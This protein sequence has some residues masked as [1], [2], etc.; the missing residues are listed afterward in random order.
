MRVLLTSTS[1]PRAEDDWRGVFIRNLTFAL[2]ALPEVRLSVW[3]PP[4]PLPPG[5]TYAC[6]PA[7][8]AWLD[9]LAARGG[10]AQ[11][12]RS[13]SLAALGSPLKLLQLLGRACK[14]S[15]AE[16]VHANWLQ[17]ALALRGTRTPVV[18][19]VLGTDFA[20]LKLPGMV[21]LLRHVLKGRR[22]A[23]APNA[24]WM[25]PRLQECFGDLA[26]IE[27]VPFGVDRRWYEIVRAPAAA[28]RRW[29]AVMRLTRAKLGPLLEWGEGV[30]GARDELHLFG[31]DQERVALPPWVRWHGPTNADALAG[32][33]MP[34][35]SGLITLSAHDEGLPQVL[36]EAMAAGLPVIA[37]RIAGHETVVE[38]GVTGSLVSTRQEFAAALAAL[39]APGRNTAGGA[40]ARAKVRAEFGTW[41]DCARRYLSLYRAVLA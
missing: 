22:C 36:L 30:F 31:P 14:R 1:Y 32:E 6:E 26:R 7:E 23:I 28:P 10:I 2:A 9:Q 19:S 4:G 20:L 24:P 16:L 8:A 17:S 38:H 13:R 37:S 11:A 18:A 15:D 27:T 5:A 33:W 21:P 12:L 34:G 3:A 29:L 39:S 25:L 35:A 40:A 41:E